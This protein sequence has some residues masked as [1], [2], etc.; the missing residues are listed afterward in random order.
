MTREEQKREQVIQNVSR[1]LRKTPFTVE[2]D[3]KKKPGIRI[4]YEVT[5]EEMDAIMGK[6]IINEYENIH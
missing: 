6:S 5:Q 4:V 3:V 2:F 1:M